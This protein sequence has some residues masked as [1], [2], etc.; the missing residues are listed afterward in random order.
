MEKLKFFLILI[1]FLITSLYLLPYFLGFLKASLGVDF[2]SGNFYYSLDGGESF[3][4]QNRGLTFVEINDLVIA[5]SGKSFYLLTN[6]GLFKSTQLEK[7]WQRIN[8]QTGILKPPVKVQ[9]MVFLKDNEEKILLALT[10]NKRSYLYLSSDG[11]KTLEEVYRT[12]N[13]G[14][15]ILDLKFHPLA[16]KIFFSTNRG[17]LVI[18][19]DQARTYRFLGYF[20]QP[21]R[22]ILFSPNDSSELILV[23]ETKIYQGKEGVGFQELNDLSF[24]GRINRVFLTSKRFYLASSQGAWQSLDGGRTWQIIDSLLPQNLPALEIVY[25][26]MKKELIVAFDG[27]LYFSSDFLNWRVKTI[28]Q[29]NLIKIVK[30]SPFN[31]QLILVALQ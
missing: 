5:P 2:S 9:R 1:I 12:N 29:T 15:E 8:D 26:N 25:N 17:Q 13:L 22:E 23:G 16:E 4:K 21:I 20:P 6:Q 19:S 27:A 30:I 10:K 31:P 7:G 24:L 14:E 3:S 28:D 18:S 11:L